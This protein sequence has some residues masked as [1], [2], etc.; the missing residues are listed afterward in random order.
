LLERDITFASARAE[1]R[2]YPTLLRKVVVHEFGHAIGLTHSGTCNDV[3]SLAADCPR[4]DPMQLPQSPTPHDVE[5]CRAIYME[6][7]Q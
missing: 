1:F 4:A 7:R 6:H 5:R 3:M 2:N